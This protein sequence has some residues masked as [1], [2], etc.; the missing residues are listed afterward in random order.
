[1]FRS[2][3]WMGASL[4]MTV[5][6]G[7]MIP[8]SQAQVSTELPTL[9]C[10]REIMRNLASQGSP[11]T[12]ALFQEKSQISFVNNNERQVSGGGKLLVTD[13]NGAIK[14]PGFTYTCVAN[15]TNAQV[16]NVDIKREDQA[17]ATE[18]SET[19][20]ATPVASDATLINNCQAEL[21]KQV[22]AESSG[23]DIGGIVNINTGK[24]QIEFPTPSE[25]YKISDTEQ[26]IRGKAQISSAGGG[27]KEVSYQC[28]A[29][30]AEG[31]ISKAS[32][33]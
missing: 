31:T 13:A 22:S 16:A 9:L 4:G 33:Q 7:S 18:P 17:A 26:G 24:K 11:E 30:K 10:Q 5:L 21:K 32:Y 23:I 28:S 15:I 6:L 19:E 14:T 1:M 25:V 29:D 8:A 20:T 12:L 27:T 3:R 2:A